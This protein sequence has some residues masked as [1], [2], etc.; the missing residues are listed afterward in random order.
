[1]DFKNI[2]N[3]RSVASFLKIRFLGLGVKV[4]ITGT[5]IVL[6][7]Y[8]F[9][10][11]AKLFTD[12][13]STV[14]EDRNG[15]LLSAVI[16]RDGQWR[17]PERHNVP[18]KF[19]TAVIT[20]EDKRFWSHPG[21]DPLSFGRALYQNIQ[22]G[23]IVSGGSTISMQVIRL[24][25]KNQPRSVFEKLAEMVLAT[26]LEFRYSKNE[27]LS[28][29]ASHAPFGGNVVGLDAACWRYFGRQPDELSW[30]EAALLAV[31]PNA[32]SLIHPGKNRMLLAAKRNRLLDKLRDQGVLD[33][34]SCTL[35]KQ[36]P[37]PEKPHALP[38][39][40]R[41][42][43]SRGVADGFGQRRITST[44]DIHLQQ[45]IEQILSDHHQRLAA[46]QVYNIATVVAKVETGEVVAYVGNVPAMGTQEGEVDVVQAAR[47]TGSILKP[48]LYAAMLD[49]GKILP[50][51]LLPD[52]PTFINGFSPKNFSKQF[53]GAVAA[54]E[55]LIRSLNIPAVH[56]L[57]NYRY[58]KFHHLL[59]NA[60][61]TTLI[62][63]P[64]HYGLSLIL[65]GAEGT[66][67]D[68]AGMYASM[69]RTLNHYYHFPGKN[70][71]SP[72]DFH[73]LKYLQGEP[74]V[75]KNPRVLSETSVIS[76]GAIFQTFDVLKELSRPGEESGWRSFHSTKKIAWKT[77]TSFGFRDG[78][79]VGVTPDFVVGVWVGNADGEGRPGLTGTDAAAPV[80]F[81]IF[82]Q[83]P[84]HAWFSQPFGELE[85]I[86][87][88]AK[89]GYRNTPLC[90]T[91]D[92]IR[93]PS[94]GLL[95]QA[96][97][98]HKKVHLT[99]DKKYRVHSACA[100]VDKMVEASWF[101]LPPVQEYYYRPK[102][103]SYKQ[104][105]ALRKDCETAASF[106]AMDIIYPKPDA[107]IFIPRSLDG[108]P[109]AAVFEL[110]HRDP[111]TTVFWHLDG[112]Y[113]GSTKRNH[114]M[115]VHPP[116]GRHK[117]TIMDEKGD[118]VE[119]TF[120]VLSKI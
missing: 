75:P 120:E 9:C 97:P 111:G 99:A 63:P 16:A 65:G 77:G 59:K 73:A 1:M 79:A 96:C 102:N 15:Q 86:T 85:Q 12:P 67:W 70:K 45:R 5:I 106:P 40:A 94:N 71:Y 72:E 84:G 114:Q 91:P 82:S 8:Y 6:V 107:R 66:L 30:S 3:K 87:V 93:V 36:E 10:L 78:W 56:L 29:Y 52:V 27:I 119:Q 116:E 25:R 23:K 74:D 112:T 42:L 109:G 95:S 110:A 117:L 92:T 50:R 60:G 41:H 69:A 76:A 26:R 64:D 53:D 105:P 113:I 54:D 118:F 33:E 13:S 83:L 4:W 58:E 61:M 19:A 90:G 81:D 28:L 100:S 7:S 20:F 31:L 39:Y 80:M 34:V 44:L 115:P 101:L 18:D 17:F 55:A 35:A 2:L 62:H 104:L 43:I 46:N 108:K 103:I 32:P 89:S 48:F 57:R 24:S 11:P 14:L 88:C 22:R 49:E 47:S 37:I 51:T 68:V 21:V 98:Y 38:Q